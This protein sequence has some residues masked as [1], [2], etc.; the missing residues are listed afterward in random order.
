VVVTGVG[1]ALGWGIGA[2]FGLGLGPLGL[3]GGFLLV[4]GLGGTLLGWWQTLN[5]DGP[6]AEE[7]RR[8]RWV[9]LNALGGAAYGSLALALL[10][11]IRFGMDNAKLEPSELVFTVA[12]PNALYA[13]ISATGVVALAREHERARRTAS[14]R[15]GKRSS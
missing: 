4:G 10:G 1:W 3:A 9:V 7:P 2:T 8:D 11:P 12:L 14:R 15:A 5:G 6:L 13:A